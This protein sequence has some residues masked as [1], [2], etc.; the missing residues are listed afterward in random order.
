MTTYGID[1]GTTNSALA[2]C[3]NGSTSV[4]P[5]DSPPGEWLTEGF[6]K[7]LPSV[8]GIDAAGDWTFGWAAKQPGRRRLD[9]AKRLLATEDRIEVGAEELFVEEAAGA[10]FG[11]IRDGGTAA[12]VAFD[13]A[14]VTIPANSRGLA[15][16]R[17]RICAGLAGIETLALLNEP[18][19]AAM[20]YGARLGDDDRILV[21]DLG[22]GTLDVTV[23]HAVGGV[24]MEQAS[25][26]I[27]RLG[28]VDFD[29][30]IAR[31]VMDD[32]PAS[33]SWS[34]DLRQE[35]LLDVELAKIRLSSRTEVA[36]PIPGG[37]TRTVTR[38]EV[39]G[40]L[41][42][43]VTRVEEPIR[44]A[45]H[46]AGM[47]M[48]DVD[49]L[50]LV[51]GSCKM[52]A[53]AERIVELV[54]RDPA[55]GIDPMTAVAEGAAV[56]AAILRGEYDASF[57]VTTEHALGTQVVDPDPGTSFSVIIPK[58]ATLPA[59]EHNGYVPVVDF[60][61][62]L[63]VVVIEGDER[64]AL[65]DEVNVVLAEWSIS[66]PTPRPKDEVS[67][68]I[69]Y[70]YDTDG[71][72]HVTVVD[73]G[74]GDVIH[75]GDVGSV[76]GRSPQQLV[77]MHRHVDDMRTSAP[78]PPVREV[79]GAADPSLP[80]EVAAALDRARVRVM[81]MVAES[82]A[83]TVGDLAD[84][85]EAAAGTDGEADALEALQSALRKWSFLF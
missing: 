70:E 47:T 74:T 46:R 28:G 80:P 37:G 79:G 53:V 85:L 20:A 38:D 78:P 44:Q 19:A 73:E 25:D 26:G 51:G 66:I 18:T 30:E 7:V 42:P 55:E 40:W 36:L 16:Y 8:I 57:Y 61:E 14:V 45:L 31:R 15:R 54:R 72:L 9:A 83:A 60:Q 17:T 33:N 35:F 81:P 65:E 50:L 56:A 23:L 29:Q 58:T 3:T 75:A 67:F 59:R 1:F 34:K 6:D 64:R 77:D 13:Q 5:I 49:H 71:I 63:H 84:A 62:N 76:V 43:F 21:V 10:L 68:D 22:G 24:F 82:D 12:G 52:P 41:D 2:S 11:R 48:N 27:Q 69:S 4:I 39:R 32:I